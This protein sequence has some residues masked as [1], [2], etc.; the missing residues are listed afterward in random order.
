MVSEA[1]TH[2]LIAGNVGLDFANTIN[3]H[4]RNDPH[5]YLK[6]YHDL[7]VWCHH[8]GILSERDARMLAQIARHR[9]TLAAKALERAR[10]LREAV[11]RVFASHVRGVKPRAVDLGM[12]NSARAEALGHSHIVSTRQGFAWKWTA[13]RSLDRLLWPIAIAATDLLVSTDLA[14]VRTCSGERC[15][16]LFVDHSRNHLRRWCSME[17]CGN[18]AKAKRFLERKRRHA[19]MR[20]VSESGSRAFS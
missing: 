10:A 19:S 7:V 11:Y 13:V 8:A 3:G 6:S 18:R 16:W 4:T 9:P 17:E 5:E 12:L 1:A 15:D 20:S 2:K 14:R